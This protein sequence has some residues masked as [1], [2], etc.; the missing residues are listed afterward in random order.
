MLYVLKFFLFHLANPQCSSG[1]LISI[2]DHL[3][4]VGSN[5]AVFHINFFSFKLK[6]LALS[7]TFPA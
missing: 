2:L 6:R 4:V 1:Y 7:R 3:Q 5:P